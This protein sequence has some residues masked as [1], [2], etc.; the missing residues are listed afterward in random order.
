MTVGHVEVLVE[1]PSAEAALRAVLPRMLGKVSFEIHQY[2]S[3]SELIKRLPQ[4]LRGYAAWLPPDHRIVVLVD[5]DDDDCHELKARL[6]ATAAKAGLSTRTG[7]GN[8]AF[9]VVNRIVIEE[10][11]AWFFGDWDAVRSAYPKVNANVPTQKK[12]RHPDAVGG[13]TWEAFERCLQNAGYF[14][15]DFGRS[16][17]LEPL[18]NIWTP[19]AT[20]HRAFVPCTTL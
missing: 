1:E 6:E 9:Q 3:K 13:G 11:E 10:L 16:R 5:R 18:A 2:G 8:D 17:W 7:S 4:R 12:Y 14:R 19:S 20:R 15:P